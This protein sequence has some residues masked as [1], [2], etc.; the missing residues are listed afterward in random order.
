M[1]IQIVTNVVGVAAACLVAHGIAGQGVGVV[2]SGTAWFGVL[3][4]VGS[5]LSGLFQ[6]PPHK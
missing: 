1:T 6:R 5:N 3:L 2:V 4:C